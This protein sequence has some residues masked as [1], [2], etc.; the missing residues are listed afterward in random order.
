[1]FSDI[2]TPSRDGVRASIQVARQ[3]LLDLGHEVTVVAPRVPGYTDTEPDIIRLASMG[4]P[5]NPRTAPGFR[6]VLPYPGLTS[7]LGRKLDVDIIHT[8]SQ[9]TMGN[10]GFQVARSRHV[11]LIHTVHGFAYEIARQDPPSMTGLLAAM[12][13][14]EAPFLLRYGRSPLPH[15]A[16]PA[17]M[18]WR[19]RWLLQYL[20]AV[21][22]LAP[23]L[24][25]PSPHVQA[26]LRSYGIKAPIHVVPSAVEPAPFQ[27]PAPLPPGATLPPARGVRIVTVGRVS[28]EKRVEELVEALSMLPLEPEWNAVIIGDGPSLETC[29]RQAQSAGIAER[30]HFMG[31][32]PTSVVGH[33]LKSS[34]VFVLASYHFDTQALTILEAVAAHLPI[35]YCDPLLTVGLE[36]N[37]LY[38]DKSPA[39]MAQALAGLIA[40]PERRAAMAGAAAKMAPAFRPIALAQKLVASYHSAIKSQGRPT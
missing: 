11:P 34:D 7:H 3:A 30:V 38:T 8:H 23:D 2:Y 40:D 10:I 16:L 1:M 18:P 21:M 20:L 5:V 17:G 14:V 39:K 27:H 29:R 22:T 36:K 25:V 24:I 4:N 9:G 33:L 12:A 35:I 37:S 28:A 6:M 26:R 32:Q 13:T 19:E 15:F 31:S